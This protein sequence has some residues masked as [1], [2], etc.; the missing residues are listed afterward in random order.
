MFGIDIIA[1]QEHRFYHPDDNLK[2]HDVGSYQ[3]VTSSASKNS[4]NATVGGIGFLLS[5]KASDNLL[6]IES[7]TPRI[8][9]LELEGNP[10]TTVICVHSPHNSSTEEDIEDFYESLRETV[11]QVPLK[12]K[13][14][15]F[16][17]VVDARNHLKA[18][19]SK[20]H[21]SPTKPLKIQLITAKKNLND[22]YLNAEVDFI[23]GKIDNLSKEHIS[24][25]HH[26][27][28]KT[29]EDLSGKFPVLQ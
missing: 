21:R 4:V 15:N 13:P 6:K 10:K 12:S 23:N 5:Q 8:L 9:V 16:L 11:E 1:I 22:A 18:V 7:V 14:S 26:L 20:Y 29:I 27:A 3:L 19:S 24:K 28:W 25:Q 17:S 2:Y